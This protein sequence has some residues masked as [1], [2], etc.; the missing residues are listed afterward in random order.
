PDT[1]GQGKGYVPQQ[2]EGGQAGGQ[3]SSHQEQGGPQTGPRADAQHKGTGQGIA[4]QGLH[5]QPAQGKSP[6]HQNGGKGLG[7]AV[8]PNDIGPAIPRS[9]LEQDGNHL[10]KGDGHRTGTDVQQPG[11]Q[12]GDP[13]EH[14]GVPVRSWVPHFIPGV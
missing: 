1:R 10:G 4:E 6:A 9:P 12:Q 11:K 8:G 5:Q 13:Q 7:D 14:K 2:G 3:G